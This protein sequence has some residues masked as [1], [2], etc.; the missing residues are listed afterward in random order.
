MRLEKKKQ[1]TEE[2]KEKFSKSE[3]VIVA[4]YKGLNVTTINSLRR[5]LREVSTDFQVAKNTLLIRAAEDTPMDVLK[6]HF[7]GPSAIAVSYS[8]PVAPARVLSEFAKEN[9]HLNVKAGVIG[10]KIIS[11]DDIKALS[12]LP[13]REVLLGKTLSVMNGVPTAFVRVLSGVI[14]QFVNVLN[15]LKDRQEAA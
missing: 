7:K 6:A 11:A 15:A 2:L 1:I 10:Q 14:V 9:K 8:D 12:T 5:K 13:S 4:D 3:V